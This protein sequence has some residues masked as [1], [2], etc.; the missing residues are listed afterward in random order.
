MPKIWDLA[1]WIVSL[2]PQE[3][4][5][6][7]LTVRNLSPE[8]AK[9][10]AATLLWKEKKLSK[11]QQLEL[12][13]GNPFSILS[14]EMSEYK[15]KTINWVTFLESIDSY[16]IV[17]QISWVKS[18]LSRN[19]IWLQIFSWY[20]KLLEQ[21]N[22]RLPRESELVS[23]IDKVWYRNFLSILWLIKRN[24]LPSAYSI[25]YNAITVANW[26]LPIPILS[27]DWSLTRYARLFNDW[28]EIYDWDYLSFTMIICVDK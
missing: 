20:N 21:Y 3:V 17:R 18:Y 16:F 4:E 25:W 28:Y 14:F 7:W 19:L 22:K 11:V 5:E 27:D 9:E 10:L 6:L 26:D 13:N 23:Y 8:I 12:I 2:L 15:E 1:S 24:V